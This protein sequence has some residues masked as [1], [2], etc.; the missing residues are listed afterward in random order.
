MK[1]SYD[2]IFFD[3]DGC[4]AKT[5]D[6]ILE[7]YRELFIKFGL[8][9]T[10]QELISIWGDWRGPLKLG[11]SEEDL[12]KWIEEY[13]AIVNLKS[14]NAELYDGAKEMLQ[15]LKGNGKKLALLSSSEKFSI[16]PSLDR[17]NLREF[18]E[19]FLS[20]N[21]VKKH[22]PDPE[23]IEKAISLIGGTK[24]KSII[25]GDSKS[26]VGAA[27]NAG[28]D[29]ILFYPKHNEQFYNKESLDKLNPTYIVN[30]FK[31]IFKIVK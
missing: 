27:H 25:I 6:V 8:P 31:E 22:K 11:I 7:I 21:D 5:L 29:C 19:F 9:K 26:D 18:F 24:E 14:P 23:I 30:D 13:K 3:W 28:I 1:K 12:P 2:Y 15:Q 4:L 20:A 10:D 16:E 17:N